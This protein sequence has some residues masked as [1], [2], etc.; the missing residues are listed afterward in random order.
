MAYEE[1]FKPY[2]EIKKLL[3]SKKQQPW[4]YSFEL[5]AEGKTEWKKK[6]LDEY[7][8][9]PP[10][11]R[12]IIY[13]ATGAKPAYPEKEAFPDAASFCWGAQRKYGN[14]ADCDG[15]D[16]KCSLAI[17]LYMK[18]WDTKK[19]PGLTFF[20]MSNN[21]FGE[22]KFGGDTMNSVQNGVMSEIV[23]YL[24]INKV[25]EKRAKFNSTKFTIELYTNNFYAEGDSTPE[26]DF[27]GVLKKEF[28]GFEKYV[29]S[30]HTLGNFVLVPAGFNGKRGMNYNTYDFW[31]SSLV[32]LKNN[33]FVSDKAVFSTDDFTKYINYFFLWDYVE[34]DG[35]KYK[36]RPLFASHKYIES[37]NLEKNILWTNLTADINE[38]DAI[39]KDFQEVYEDTG[40][41]E[42]IRDK[43]ENIRKNA[44]E[45]MNKATG[46]ITRRGIFMTALLRLKCSD[47]EIIKD[48]CKEYF[49]YIQGGDF[50]NEAHQDGYKTAV[51]NLVKLLDKAPDN[52]TAKQIISDLSKII[53]R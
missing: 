38:I 31:D 53:S 11:D 23:K 41:I 40:F 36:V 39:K 6:A 5:E 44:A 2:K 35:D 12:Y 48:I 46:L 18:L 17:D 26:I 22:A 4:A 25:V 24:V 1:K 52:D 7:K 27:T 50:L 15:S 42:A 9:K 30:Y 45:F 33:G 10:I 29:E 3:D 28:D 32:W 21:I 8:D 34:P 51:D 13:K 49:G 19:I 47:D 16:G 14:I 20:Q 37:G 43:G